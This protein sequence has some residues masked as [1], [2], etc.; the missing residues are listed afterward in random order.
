MQEI[1]ENAAS[2]LPVVALLLLCLQF[3]RLG[4]KIEIAL[5]LTVAGILLVVVIAYGLLAV[6]GIDLVLSVAMAIVWLVVTLLLFASAMN[7][8]KRQRAKLRLEQAPP[9]P[10]DE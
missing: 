4:Q 3:T 5:R 9:N 10:P 2:L 8:R 7:L 1:V 6:W